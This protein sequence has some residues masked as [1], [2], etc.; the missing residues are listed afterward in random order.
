[1]KENKM[2]EPKLLQEK[3]E[4]TVR[5]GMTAHSVNSSTQEAEAGRIWESQLSA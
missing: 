5:A 2:K 1:M 3:K 4:A